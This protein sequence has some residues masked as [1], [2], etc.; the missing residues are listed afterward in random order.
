MWEKKLQH[1]RI[2]STNNY[3]LCVFTFSMIFLL[4]PWKMITLIF[5]SETNRW[6]SLN[7]IVISNTC[8]GQYADFLFFFL[9]ICKL[10]PMNKRRITNKPIPFLV[11]SFHFHLFQQ[12]LYLKKIFRFSVCVMTDDRFYGRRIIAIWFVFYSNVWLLLL[13]I[14][15]KT[16]FIMLSCLFLFSF[17]FFSFK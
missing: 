6:S 15:A 11:F 5:T 2:H 14:T 3:Y 8:C 4:I 17:L 1:N 16:S 9:V 12:V 7:K 13:L 10:L